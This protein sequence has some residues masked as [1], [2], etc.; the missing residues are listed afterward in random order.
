MA[1]PPE[2]IQRPIGVRGNG[3]VLA[4]PAEELAEF[5]IKYTSANFPGLNYPKAGVSSCNDRTS[6]VVTS[7]DVTDS[8]GVAAAVVAPT[9]GAQHGAFPRIASGVD[10][11]QTRLSGGTLCSELFSHFLQQPRWQDCAWRKTR[12]LRPGGR[13][14]RRPRCPQLPRAH[15]HRGVLRQR[16]RRPPRFPINTRMRQK[17]VRDR[18]SVV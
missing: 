6:E 14:R 2:L 12:N 4:R 13:R 8:K 17:P 11:Q 16:C 15:M 1:E 10:T 3:A 7:A 5:G 18:K 9:V